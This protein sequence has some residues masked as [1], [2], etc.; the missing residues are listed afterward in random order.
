MAFDH[1]SA[2]IPASTPLATAADTVSKM[3][4]VETIASHKLLVSSIVILLSLL[5]L[6]QAVYR[7]KKGRLPGAQWKI[8][9]IGK[10]F[11]SMHPSMENYQKQ[12][13]LGPLSVVSVFHM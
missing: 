8:P 5:I 1:P 3:L 7:S 12:W 4:N 2:S 13:D 11:D 9:I 10:F 6:E